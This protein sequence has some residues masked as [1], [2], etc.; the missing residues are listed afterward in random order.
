ML[1][2]YIAVARTAFRR[3]LIYRWANIAGLLTNIFFGAIFSY[4]IIALYHARPSAAGYNVHD[5]L[6][7]TWLVQGMIMIVL[8]FGWYDVMLSIRSGDVISD[9]S[10]P[11]DYYWYWFSRELGRAC[12]YTLFRGIPTYLAG[13][14]LFGIDVPTNWHAW[15]IYILILPLS[16]M[17]GIAYR[18]LYN[19][20]AFWITEAR[21]VA[22]LATTIA[23]FLT[24]SFVPFPFFPAWFRAIAVWLPFN[25]L[26]NFPAEIFLN[27]LSSSE[28]WLGS[29]CLILWLLVL[30]L[31]VRW[32]T[33]VATRRVVVQG[34]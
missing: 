27:K 11:Y 15:F 18:Y 21:A 5:T 24:G 17:L 14:V 26:M 30:T 28:I 10:K 23:L 31:F 22:V 19:V 3:Q 6:R 16:A 1:R 9:L 12:Y 34:G 2:F 4:L 29:S 8:P 33:T 20:V 32:I 25:G 13:M 7:Y